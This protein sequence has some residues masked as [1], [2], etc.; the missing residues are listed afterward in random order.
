MYKRQAYG[1]KLAFEW[2]RLDGEDPMLFL[3]KEDAERVKIPDTGDMLP[4]EIARFT[5]SMEVMDEEEKSHLSF[6]QG[7]GHGL[8]L[9]HIFMKPKK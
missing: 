6:I 7:S 9:I 5:R 2:N 3:G 4:K 1:N 8:S